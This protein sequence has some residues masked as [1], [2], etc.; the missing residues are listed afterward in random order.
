VPDVELLDRFWSKVDIADPDGCW[1]WTAAKNTYGYGAFVLD[2]WMRGAHRIAYEWLIG[3][4]PPGMVLDHLVCSNRACVNP[5]HL[6][7]CTQ[8][9]NARRAMAKMTHCRRGHEYNEQN[10]LVYTAPGKGPA[11]FCRICIRGR[12]Q[13][14]AIERRR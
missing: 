8:G 14:A 6:D 10:T 12:R 2:G 3:P 5:A 13:S 9:E 4:I 11:R 1:I 7:L